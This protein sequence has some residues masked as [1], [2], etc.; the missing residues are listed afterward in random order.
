MRTN[1]SYPAMRGI[2]SMLFYDIGLSVIAY[3]V[4]ELL[5]ASNY[6]ALLAGT[7]V[8][9]LRML[10]VAIRQR[11]LDPF[12]LFL[13]TLF[14]AGLALSFVTGDPRFLLAKD[15]STTSTAGLVL[16]ISCLIG[17]PLA[18]YAALRL[19]RSAGVAEQKRF[20]ATAHTGVMRTRWYR[21]SLVWGVALLAD[22][23]L[24]ITAIYTLPIGLAANLSQVLTVAVY[25]LLILWTIMTARTA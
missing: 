16:V 4:A 14:G 8:A 17:R 18:Y 20:R 3:F 19:S 22:A 21:V 23:A 13:I 6:I 25:G 11:R 9:G 5:G 12:A 15:A 24:R 10:W 7:V 1:L 2:V